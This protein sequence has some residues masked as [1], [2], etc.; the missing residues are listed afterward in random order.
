MEIVRFVVTPLEENTYVVAGP[1]GSCVVVDPGFLSPRE[2]ETVLGFMR[3][4]GLEPEA[5]LLTHGHMDHIYGVASIQKKFGIPVYMSDKDKHIVE[6]FSRL[7]KWGIP[8][9]DS[10]FTTT[11]ISDGSILNV[12]GLGFRV[13]ATPGH[14]P[15]GVCYLSQDSPALFTGDTLFAGTIGRTDLEGGDYD[16]LIASVLEKLIPLD[17]E[18]EVLPGHGASSTISSERASNPFLEPFNEPIEEYD[19]D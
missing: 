12:A 13:I 1:S 8:V 4:K 16:A 15:G 7:G 9:A 10:G 3:S 6:Y 19:K 18:T 5:V 11:D 2:E 14:T 17:G